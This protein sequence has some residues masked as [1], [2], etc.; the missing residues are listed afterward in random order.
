M[1][2]QKKFAV[3]FF[4]LTACCDVKEGTVAEE[5]AVERKC[6]IACPAGFNQRAVESKTPDGRAQA[7]ATEDGAL[8]GLLAEWHPNGQLSRRGAYVNGKQEGTWKYWFD[9]GEKL[10]QGSYR[11]GAPDGLWTYW[12]MTGA[13]AE[14]ATFVGGKKNGGATFWDSEGTKSSVIYRDNQYAK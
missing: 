13:K 12:H 11:E 14:E 6:S 2:M 8:G 10:K 1:L 7:C 3:L 5:C 4:L 9:N